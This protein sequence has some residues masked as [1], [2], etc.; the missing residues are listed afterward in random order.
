MP[1]RHTAQQSAPVGS[2]QT[3]GIRYIADQ[4]AVFARL[5]WH[6]TYEP[7]A[8]AEAAECLVMLCT[9]KGCSELA[10]GY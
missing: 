9:L 10:G 6:V 8:A 7:T 5:V 1:L 4:E 2:Q 3:V